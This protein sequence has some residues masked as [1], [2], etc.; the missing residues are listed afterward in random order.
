MIV[1]KSKLCEILGV[2]DPTITRYVNDGMPMKSRGSRGIPSEFNT[3]DVVTWLI[4]RETVKVGS[5]TSETG[6]TID[7]YLEQARL[8]KA[9]ADAQELKNELERRQVAPVQVMTDSIVK[10]GA[11]AVA[12][13]AS[14]KLSVKRKLPYLKNT[15]LDIIETEV[16]R[17]RNAIADMELVFDED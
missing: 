8:T 16:A 17:A 11:S 5:K 10:V 13:L 2:V 7:L 12:I 4:R 3:Q 14:L 9:K 15:E 1:S 6:E